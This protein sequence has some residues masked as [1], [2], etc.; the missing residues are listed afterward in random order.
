MTTK[1]F[2]I[3]INARRENVWFALW[4]DYHYRSWTS[5]FCEG[6]YAVTDW[7]EGSKV[8][9]LSPGGEGM[10][11]EITL[12]KPNE[13][14]YFTHKGELR[15]FEELPLDEKS[16]LWS[17]A[18]EN[19]SLTEN[20]GVTTLKVVIDLVDEHIDYF[21]KTFPAGLAKV[22]D[23][24]ENLRIV[25]ETRINT[26]LEKAWNSWTEPSHIVKWNNASD[27]WHTPHAENDLRTGGKFLS[28]ME[29]KDGSMG[30][31]FGGEYSNVVKYE[32]IEYQMA[33]NRKV[34]VRFQN[35]DNQVIITESFEPELT[36]SLELQKAGWQ[37]ILDNFKKYVESN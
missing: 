30:F 17:G 23:L 12:L 21:S 22:K 24:A 32:L 13:K 18:R 26:S 14:M 34:S 4:D 15:N 7:I 19:Y 6:S 29:A 1:E 37:S 3:D 11:S 36:N 16:S 9:F 33:D 10:Y 31:D 28:R 27:D 2:T 35:I 5:V 20:D 25:I 8:H